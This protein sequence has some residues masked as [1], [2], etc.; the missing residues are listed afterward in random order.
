MTIENIFSSEGPG[1]EEILTSYSDAG[2]MYTEILEFRKVYHRH[3]ISL[4]TSKR[5]FK[6]LGLHKRPLVPW[7]A[8]TEK[9]HNAAKKNRCWRC[10]FRI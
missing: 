7:R 1:L 4:S 10:K 2:F 8:A 9:V 5:R 3:Q 6:A